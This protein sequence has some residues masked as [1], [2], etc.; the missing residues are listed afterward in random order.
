MR[1]SWVLVGTVYACLFSF[2]LSAA[3]APSNSELSELGRV[4]EGKENLASGSIYIYGDQALDN[5]MPVRVIGSVAKAGLHYVPKNLDLVTLITLAGGTGTDAD[6]EK[7]TIKRQEGDKQQIIAINLENTLS[8]VD[9]ANPILKA[10]DTVYIPQKE[11]I[12]SENVSRTVT[13]IVGITSIAA[14][15]FVISRAK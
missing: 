8:Q 2:T 4:S 10:G 5:L 11:M 12:V 9:A 13:L 14:S 7:L 15:I 3:I 1:G 6:V